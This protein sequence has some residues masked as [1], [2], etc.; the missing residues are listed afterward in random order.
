MTQRVGMGYDIHAFEE[1]RTLVLGGITF[2]GETGL[3]GHSDADVLVHAIIDALLGAAG[4]GDIGRHFP[5]GAEK[6]A[7][8]SSLD[9]LGRTAAMLV[10]ASISVGNID[11]TVIAERPLLAG[12]LPDMKAAVATALGV[13]EDQVNIKAT[14]NEGLGPVGRGEGMAAMAVALVT[15]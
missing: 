14:T 9:L 10:A 6:W 8:A 4:L 3:A 7:G 1:G 2:P 12:R 15:L 13:R 11:A 5:P